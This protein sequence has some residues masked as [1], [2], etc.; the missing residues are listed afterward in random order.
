[1]PPKSKTTK[2]KEE[3]TS[4]KI[5][6][7]PP[8]PAWRAEV[9]EEGVE[10]EA[11]SAKSLEGEEAPGPEGLE[12]RREKPK[13]ETPD[14]VSV[15]EP[16]RAE[17]TLGEVKPAE[18]TSSVDLTMS[19]E[20]GSQGKGK[21]VFI[22]VFVLVLI[23]GIVAGGLFYYKS[24]VAVTKDE[25]GSSETVATPTLGSQTTPTPSEEV[26]LSD[27]SVQILNGS[28]IP[29]EA[30]K[31]VDL[32]KKEGFSDLKTGNADSYSY[33]ISEI[34]LKKDTPEA[35]FA[36]VKKAMVGY[37]IVRQEEALDAK[38]DFDIKIV[39]GATKANASPT[40]SQ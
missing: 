3:E 25:S 34:S 8:V 11:A 1:M 5:P 6:D 28:G 37:K 23:A 39:V 4:E 14:A 10:E 20:E 27:Y 15:E 21:K 26:K 38:G 31:V 17:E 30:G 12:A 19:S 29:G 9:V 32:L 35:V 13:E 22:I 2:V 33:T 40:P 24:K 18:E 36:A 16:A 7:T